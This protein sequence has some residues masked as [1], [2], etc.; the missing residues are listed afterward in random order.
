MLLG[1]NGKWM[2]LTSKAACMGDVIE[3]CPQSVIDKFILVTSLDSGLVILDEQRIKDGWKYLG[4]KVHNQELLPLREPSGEFALSP[5]VTNP[6]DI[7][8]DICHGNM[9]DEWYVFNSPPKI[10]EAEVFINWGDFHLSIGH[11][12][13]HTIEPHFFE[14]RF[15]NQITVINPHAYIADNGTLLFATTDGCLYEQVLFA[16]QNVE[17]EMGTACDAKSVTGT[18]EP[19]AN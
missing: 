14:E 3:K 7:P 8:R 13:L 17:F 4:K 5:R 6:A 16:V 2:W 15:W 12:G 18:S 1:K 9:Y 11:I 19:G 10:E